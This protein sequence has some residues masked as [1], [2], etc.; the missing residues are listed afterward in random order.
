MLTT[1]AFM[2]QE[3]DQPDRETPVSH[4]TN[5]VPQ[6]QIGV[7]PAPE[8]IAA[9]LDWVSQIQEVEVRQT[10]GSLPGALGFWIS[11]DSDPDPP[12]GN[13]WRSGVRASSP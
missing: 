9:L 6:V 11:E 2:A 13:C 8:I 12:K 10:V 3:V 1:P 5:S 4:V 7:N